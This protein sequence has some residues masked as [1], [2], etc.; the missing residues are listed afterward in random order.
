MGSRRFL[1]EASID[2]AKGDDAN[3]TQDD[4]NSA[5]RG[6][7]KVERIRMGLGLHICLLQ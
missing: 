6:V 3:Y 7:G 5:L 1:G 4:N 2:R